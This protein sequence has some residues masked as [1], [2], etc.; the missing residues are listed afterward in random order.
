MSRNLTVGRI[1]IPP[2][3]ASRAGWEILSFSPQ[4]WHG[5]PGGWAAPSIPRRR[6]LARQLIL[7]L[8]VAVCGAPLFAPFA[9]GVR[10]P[11]QLRYLL[12]HEILEARTSLANPQLSPSGE[13]STSGPAADGS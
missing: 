5:P 6:L 4:T 2:D 8:A 1:A 13:N 11:T 12:S 9:K 7:D 3:F 10:L